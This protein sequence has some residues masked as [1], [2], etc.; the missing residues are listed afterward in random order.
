MDSGTRSNIDDVVGCGHHVFI[1]FYHENGVPDL[2]KPLHVGD[3][4]VVVSRMEPYRR[5]VKYVYDAFK[6]RPDLGSK[7]Y[8]LRL[9]S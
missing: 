4:H 9:S 7:P 2:D 6:T 3:K 5:F 8:S 1:M